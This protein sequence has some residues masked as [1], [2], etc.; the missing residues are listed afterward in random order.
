MPYLED[1]QE[2]TFVSRT[3][4]IMSVGESGVEHMLLDLIDGQTNPTVATYAKDN[5]SLVRLTACAHT[6]KEAKQLID[7]IA[8]E[9]YRRLGENIYGED[10]TSIE[11]VV[12]RL[13]VEKGETIAVSESCTGGMVSSALI[14]FPGIS[15]VFI[16]GDVTYSNDAKIRRLGVKKE[17]LELFGAVSK[18]TAAEMAIGIAQAAGTKIGISTTGIAGP[19]G[20]SEQKPVG[21]VYAGLYRN[22]SVKTQ[23]FHFAGT[24]QRIRSRATAAVL[25]WLRRELITS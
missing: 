2:E 13:L 19:D 21:L 4:R 17:T 6:K 16:E 12:A 10:E 22:G 25:D 11:E 1:R 18:E 23:E 9:I 5:E 14:E 15:K 8:D 3:L 7:P 24:R 20:G